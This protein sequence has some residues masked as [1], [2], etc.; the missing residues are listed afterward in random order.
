MKV[1]FFR[2]LVVGLL[3]TSGQAFAS[4][5]A[6]QVADNA[7]L[8]KL[9][10]DVCGRD[11]V[12]LGEESNHGNTHANK[13]RGLLIKR[14]VQECGFKQVLFESQVYDFV[15]FEHEMS[16][17]TASREQLHNAVG[18]FWADWEETQPLLAWLF[19]ETKA[20]NLRL[21]GIDPQTQN[22]YAK[23]TAHELGGILATFLPQTKRDECKTAFDR[24]NRWG[25]DATYPFDDAEKTRLT[26]C[27][28]LISESLSKRTDTQDESMMMAH[29]WLRYEGFNLKSQSND[30]RNDNAR[31]LGLYE[32]LMWYL[33]RDKR[34]TIVWCATVHAAKSGA[35]GYV[36]MDQH[37]HEQLGDRM[38]SI[39]FT[40][41]SGSYGNPLP[42]KSIPP[43]QPD[44]LEARATPTPPASL[45]Y[46]NHA[47]LD[48]FGEI[49]ALLLDYSKPRTRNWAEVLDGLIVL[50]AERPQT[51][52]AE[53]K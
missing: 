26:G 38:A 32:L 30:V 24:Y 31:D 34:K 4:D 16:A 19:D 12:V 44:W 3:L 35:D 2:G 27:N 47:E 28:D 11:V 18:R 10:Q 25:Y 20:G 33:N 13:I 41:T 17:G 46:L 42:V 51:P 48:G 39:G 49:P 14:L 50:D 37:L 52:I 5:A 53:K 8:D 21:G 29:A 15:N 40:A 23:F 43:L 22:I 36:P 9:V 6:T 45:R 7:E 1:T